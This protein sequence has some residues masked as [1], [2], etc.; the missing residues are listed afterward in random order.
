[1][2]TVRR[3]ALLVM[4]VFTSCGCQLPQCCGVHVETSARQHGSA[5]GAI[6][7]QPEVK[8]M[9]FMG[10]NDPMNSWD[11]ISA[12]AET[13]SMLSKRDYDGVAVVSSLMT[14]VSLELQSGIESVMAVAA[15]WDYEQLWPRIK[16]SS[17][18][19]YHTNLSSWYRVLSAEPSPPRYGFSLVASND[20]RFV[21]LH[22]GFTNDPKYFTDD[23]SIL[24]DTWRFDIATAGWHK[25]N[26]SD[27]PGGDVKRRAAHSAVILRDPETDIAMMMVFGGFTTSNQETND[28]LTLNLEYGVWDE[29]EHDS[30]SLWPSPRYMHSAATTINNTMLIFGAKYDEVLVKHDLWEF[31]LETKQWRELPELNYTI[32]EW[33]GCSSNLFAQNF[34]PNVAYYYRSLDTLFV[35]PFKGGRIWLGDMPRALFEYDDPLCTCYF[36]RSDPDQEWKCA[37]MAM[38]D[39]MDDFFW[40]AGTSGAFG[41]YHFGFSYGV[42]SPTEW[43]FNFSE[44]AHAPGVWQASLRQYPST[45]FSVPHHHI[46]STADY[47]PATNTVFLFGGLKLIDTGAVWQEQGPYDLDMA[48]NDLWLYSTTEDT[49]SRLQLNNTPPERYAHSSTVAHGRALVI[50]SGFHR[51][52]MSLQDILWCFDMLTLKWALGPA[53]ARSVHDSLWR[54]HAIT[55]FLP[56]TNE[57]IVHGGFSPS[58]EFLNSPYNDTW[59]FKFASNDLSDVVG[60]RG[61]W[62]QLNC[63]NAPQLLGH[64]AVVYGDDVI[65]FGGAQFDGFESGFNLAPQN[66]TWRL[67][68]ALGD[69]HWEEIITTHAADSASQ[70]NVLQAR[71]WHT[72][73]VFGAQMVVAGGCIPVLTC[74]DLA[75]P[76]ACCH[77]AHIIMTHVW[78]LNLVTWEWTYIVIRSSDLMYSGMHTAVATDHRMLIFD[79]LRGSITASPNRI[80]RYDLLRKDYQVMLASPAGKSSNSFSDFNWTTCPVDSYGDQVGSK[81]CSP[82][83]ERT[84]TER[85]GATSLESCRFCSSD[86]VCYG[87]GTCVVDEYFQPHCDCQLGYLSTDNCRLPLAFLYMGSGILFLIL[88]IVCLVLC[89][90]YKKKNKVEALVQ[91]RLMRSQSQVAQLNLAWQIDYGELGMDKRVDGE[92]PGAF[93]EVWLATYRDMPVAVK[94]LKAVQIDPRS[95]LDFE[96]EVALMKTI[97]HPNIVMFLGAGLHQNQP[98]IVV[99]FM[100]RGPLSSLIRNLS[101]PVN[102]S[103]KVRWALDVAKGMHYLHSLMPPRIHRDLKTSNLLLSECWV[104]KVA[105]FGTARLVSDVSSRSP[106]APIDEED[107]DGM[108]EA[109]QYGLSTSPRGAASFDCESIGLLHS[110]NSALMTRNAGTLLWCSPEILA[111]KPYGASTDVYSFGV[112]LWELCSRKVPFSEF[113]DFKWMSKISDAVEAGRRPTIPEDCQADLSELMQQCWHHDPEQ[114]PTFKDIVR[115]LDDL[116]ETVP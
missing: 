33:Y 21:V 67:H 7:S 38:P 94:K 17:T 53:V 18:Y 25:P 109:S 37:K 61:N 64:T 104:A 50:F 112:I 3:Y 29:V 31:S 19:V 40:V 56:A 43:V 70:S 12:L 79:G 9:C 55:V 13:P 47:F 28:L 4:L 48:E 49:W 113:P 2:T 62:Q 115:T 84:N 6:R 8:T 87:H 58:N 96:R 88:M 111:G 41:I 68:R 83:P 45:S 34:S 72:S 116:Q 66:R 74:A 46:L 86:T 91:R 106:V 73:V 63:P 108:R 24:N 107:E 11:P 36:N 90:M 27:T 78:V 57:L 114:R 44:A 85:P 100:A 99:E 35:F 105:D 77:D 15:T 26:I 23:T 98:F 69:C 14:S 16:S 81:T 103:Q 95:R 20:H 5:S 102:L 54:G 80:Y 65:V 110:T 51:F 89:R 93:G 75:Y 39:K 22:G 42:V 32:I 82:C 10:S 60:C 92:T 52:E 30:S 76:L 1:M 101:I 97:R 71:L 59:A